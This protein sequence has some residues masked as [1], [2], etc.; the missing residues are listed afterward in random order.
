MPVGRSVSDRVVKTIS[1]TKQREQARNK[2]RTPT[3]NRPTP[4]RS[5]TAPASAPS[6]PA[7]PSRTS[8][9][10]PSCGPPRARHPRRCGSA[11][12]PP[13][14]PR[15]LRRRPPPRPR[16][17][18]RGSSPLRPRR[19]TARMGRSPRSARRTSCTTRPCR[20]PS[21]G[22]RFGGTARR[23]RCVLDPAA[24]RWARLCYACL[25]LV[26]DLVLAWFVQAPKRNHPLMLLSGVA[27]NAVGFDL[28][29]GVS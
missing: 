5:S 27:T 12:S 13:T 28:S 2:A 23:L 4:C 1:E 3:S 22:S 29:P 25:C 21:G 15:S 17:R 11:P 24:R 8:L 16:P 9:P 20:A 19:A 6:S 10:L 18:P 7:P 26:A 14:A